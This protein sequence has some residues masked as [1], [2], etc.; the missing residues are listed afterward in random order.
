MGKW[1]TVRVQH[2]IVEEAKKEVET[3]KYRS[4]SDFVSDAIKTRLQTLTDERIPEYLERDRSSRIRQL[5]TQLRYTPTHLCVYVT[6]Q[7]TVQIGITEH[8][9]RQ[10]R[11][12]VNIL[13]ADVGETVTKDEP[14]GVVESWWF[15]H[16]VNSPLNGTIVAVNQ[17]VLADPFLLN[18]DPYQWIVEVKPRLIFGDSWMRGLLTFS[19][20]EQ[21]VTQQT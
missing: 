8:F 4:L 16:D 2:E 19:E 20:Y 9:Q 6:P 3:G 17:A 12:I 14:F 1:K 5:Q 10:L 18:L 13:T 7:H 21:L 15:T 11:E